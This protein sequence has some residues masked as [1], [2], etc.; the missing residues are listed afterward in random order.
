M[1][2]KQIVV[3]VILLV[4]MIFTITACEKE[5]GTVI[6]FEEMLEENT[7]NDVDTSNKAE[8][9]TDFSPESK[10]EDTQLEKDPNA[11]NEGNQQEIE[12]SLDSGEESSKRAIDNSTVDRAIWGAS[13]KSRKMNNHSNKTK[14]RQHNL[15]QQ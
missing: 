6:D 9:E 5:S 11:E 3:Q 13:Y 1:R 2:K 15:Y 10:Q 14:I 8:M 12:Q 4:A 7:E